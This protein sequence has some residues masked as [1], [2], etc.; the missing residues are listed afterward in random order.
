MSERD[1]S[2]PEEPAGDGLLVD[3]D[4]PAEDVPGNDEEQDTPVPPD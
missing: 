4:A 2:P 3:E 1:P